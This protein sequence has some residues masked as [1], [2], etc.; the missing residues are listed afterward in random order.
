MR[1]IVP[2]NERYIEKDLFAFKVRNVVSAPI[3][4]DIVLIPVKTGS[5]V[6]RIDSLYTSNVYDGHIQSQVENSANAHHYSAQ[7]GDAIA[8]GSICVRRLM[9][10]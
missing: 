9:C 4:D 3:L 6:G 7:M 2:D 10:C 5:F 8:A 1:R